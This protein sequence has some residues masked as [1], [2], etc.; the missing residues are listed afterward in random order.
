[1][2]Q[3]DKLFTAYFSDTSTAPWV[4]LTG[5][6]ATI[7]IREIETGTV[8]VNDSAMT[9]IWGW[10]Y[11]Y[12]FSEMSNT[13]DYVY[14]CDPNN[15]SAYIESWVT[16][17]RINYIDSAISDIRTK[18]GWWTVVYNIIQNYI[19]NSL[20]STLENIKE[21]EK[22]HNKI[23]W[24]LW[25]K[26]DFSS[27]IDKIESIPKVSLDSIEN[28]IDNNLKWIEKVYKIIDK[29]SELEKKEMQKNHEEKIDKMKK[30]IENLEEI[31]EEEKERFD[32]E[33]NDTKSS[34]E[35]EKE[36]IYEDANEVLAILEKVNAEN[37]E[38]KESTLEKIKNLIN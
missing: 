8:I 5:L 4:P 7:I 14:S 16:D 22:N 35:K 6:S 12:T 26:I 18:S 33:F 28:K 19:N 15:S 2:A 21:L 9:E 38:S 31:Y 37:I 11:K 34:Y 27:I 20:K 29:K 10:W 1:M 32:K 24:E 3:L 23:I 17:R 25:D 36:S 13:K 30:Q